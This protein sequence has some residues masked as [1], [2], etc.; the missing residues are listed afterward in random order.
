[1]TE[2]PDPI[3]CLECLECIEC[4]E[5]TATLINP[6][7]DEYDDIVIAPSC[8]IHELPDDHKILECLSCNSLHVYCIECKEFAQLIER[9]TVMDAYDRGDLVAWRDEDGS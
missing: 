4:L 2:Q 7:N 8:E 9:S 1:M 3:A 5:C 6:G